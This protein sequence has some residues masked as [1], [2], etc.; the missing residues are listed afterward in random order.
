[1]SYSLSVQ[2]FSS[3]D[4][5]EFKKHYAA[6]KFC[7]ENDLS[8]P[9]ETSEFF[10]GNVH[11]DSLEDLRKE[12]WLENIEDGISVPLIFTD[13]YEWERRIKVSE[14]PKEVDEIVFKMV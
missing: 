7:V 8:L 3:K 12:S 5:P 11:G 2:G 10:K 14:I 9:K 1:M 6:V 13:D 4:S